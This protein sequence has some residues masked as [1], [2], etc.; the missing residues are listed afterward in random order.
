MKTRGRS[1]ERFVRGVVAKGVCALVPRETPG[2][3][4]LIRIATVTGEAAAG[5]WA[6]LLCRRHR[7]R[8]CRFATLGQSF[9]RLWGLDGGK[10]F[11]VSWCCL[12]EKTSPAETAS[13]PRQPN[14]PR[15]EAS[16]VMATNGLFRH[17]G[18]GDSR[19]LVS[20]MTTAKP[21]ESDL[22]AMLQARSGNSLMF[23]V[24]GGQGMVACGI[25][26]RSTRDDDGGSR[27]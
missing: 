26:S 2:G 7:G 19:N 18:S 11:H 23:V 9:W 21:A 13:V 5:A 8:S 27:W 4:F 25:I 6:R 3:A 1:S 16:N 12:A 24:Q 15:G 17:T 14:C 10:G 20:R 22:G